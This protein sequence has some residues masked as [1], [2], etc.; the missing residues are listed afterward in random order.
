MEIPVTF[1]QAALGTEIEVPT[2]KGKAKLSVPA[3]T[4]TDTIFKLKGQGIKNIIQ[5]LKCLKLLV[6]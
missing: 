1:S 5:S 6:E 3:Y 4:Q 2:L